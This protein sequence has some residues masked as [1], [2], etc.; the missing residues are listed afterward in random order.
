M[1]KILL[2]LLIATLLVITI[3]GKS[4]SAEKNSKLLNKE[5]FMEMES[6]GSPNIS[7]DG[8]HILF[9]RRWVDKM[10]DRYSSNIW[11]VDVEGKRVREL[12][13]GNWRDSSPVW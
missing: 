13:Q 10:N 4:F 2:L 1:R 6:V 9:T 5:T 11:I 3:P 12:T 7:P 8:K